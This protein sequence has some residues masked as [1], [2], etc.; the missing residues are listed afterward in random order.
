M[1]D[2]ICKKHS[3]EYNELDRCI[4]KEIEKEFEEISTV[5]KVEIRSCKRFEEDYHPMA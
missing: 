1:P 2:L 5:T 3:C 4:H